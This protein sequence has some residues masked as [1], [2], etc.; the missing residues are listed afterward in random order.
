M[1]GI[2]GSGLNTSQFDYLTNKITSEVITQFIKLGRKI[3]MTSPCYGA[4]F[5]PDSWMSLRPRLEP[6]CTGRETNPSQNH[7][8][9]LPANLGSLVLFKEEAE[10]LPAFT[11][12]SQWNGI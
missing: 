2:N 3:L 4:P 7:P 5:F 9:V 11:C 1:P 8:P 10:M 12:T 6:S